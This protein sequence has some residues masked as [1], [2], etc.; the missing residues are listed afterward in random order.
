MLRGMSQPPQ[1]P[2]ARTPDIRWLLALVTVSLGGYM[3]VLSLS[4][5]FIQLFTGMPIDV[6]YGVL[7]TLQLIFAL[8][9]VVLGFFFA[10]APL[11]RRAIAAGIVVAIVLLV[12]VLQAIRLSSGFGPA[13]VFIGLTLGDSFVMLALGLGSGWLVVRKRPGLSFATLALAVIL[14]LVRWGLVLNGFDLATS[15]LIMLV[16]GALVVAAIG[17]GGVL[18][19]RVLGGASSD[20]RR[21]SAQQPPQQP[22]YGVPAQQQQQYAAPSPH[23]PPYA[24]QNDRPAE[25]GPVI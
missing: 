16:L 23:Q 4:G 21:Q 19:S 22:Q 25:R 15:Q 20:A 18:A 7:L 12:I 1:P 9:V 5:Q 14:S 2:T 11:M 24:Q 17:W 13:S 10:P 6:S 3:L 8:A